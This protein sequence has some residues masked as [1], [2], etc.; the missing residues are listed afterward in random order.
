M[1]TTFTGGPGDDTY[2]VTA[3]NDA[4]VELANGGVD[5]VRTTADY[6]LPDNVENL[7]LLDGALAGTGNALANDITGN[8][9][10]NTLR[11]AGGADHLSGLAG[12]DLFLA[13]AADLVAGGMID[14]GAGTD[15]LRIEGY[16]SADLTGITL[17]ALEGVEATGAVRMTAA[18]VGALDSLNASGLE[19]AGAGDADLTGLDLLV[20][21][22]VLADAGVRLITGDP[23]RV[24]NVRGVA[25]AQVS[26]TDGTLVAFT[27]TVQ[28]ATIGTS[29][30]DYF[31]G[32]IGS[33]F[34][35]GAGYDVVELAGIRG[36]YDLR[37]Q[38]WRNVEELRGGL[39]TVTLDGDQFNALQRSD[40]LLFYR[41]SGSGTLHAVSGLGYVTLLNAGL[42]LDW[43]MADVNVS[44]EGSS[45]A[46]RVTVGRFGS[47]VNGNDGDDVIAGGAG[48]DY[49][50][51][52]AGTDRILGGAG[53]D[54]LA[55]GA[56]IDQ[57]Y[58]GA[59]DDVL[60][61]ST[62]GL[63]AGEVASGGPGHDTL[64]LVGDGNALTEIDLTR[65]QIAGMEALSPDF[66]VRMTV[67][68]L[69]QFDT[70]NVGKITVKGAALLDLG[71]ATGYIGWI[72][73]ETPGARLSLTGFAGKT[74]VTGSEGADTIHAADGGS[75]I[76]G[77]GG[78]DWLWGGIGADTLRGGAGHDRFVFATAP[79][80]PVDRIADF[81][82]VDDSVMLD[83]G[84][85][86]ALPVTH[87]AIGRAAFW[88]GAQAHDASDRIVY[89]AGT[90]A[91]YYDA[92]GNGAGGQVQFAQLSANLALTHADFIV[93]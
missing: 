85:F 37:N 70:F 2:D 3:S 14:G 19:I 23:T 27:D 77:G 52:G 38:V 1:A 67:G 91:L 74:A 25:G 65:V 55:G 17:A 80:G 9:L 15:L 11:G 28:T 34:D 93:I 42:T 48:V 58:G 87:G 29:G 30:D 76:K 24:L 75:E 5:T 43:A 66:R 33:V 79:S 36:N 6:A 82:A 68:Q 63:G 90:G 51:G 35:A 26:L 8:A 46:D 92:D 61:L 59:G 78:N 32:A 72:V 10:D 22:V 56:G 89:D 64:R 50:S 53:N 39:S 88:I 41:V 45:G 12:D 47:T 71:H 44:I 84:V 73:L 13:V 7:I 81:V 18:Q 4:I 86:T 31:L 60:I 20:G 21:D 54:R 57:V 83:H 69:A 62:A 16:A 40:G 49:L